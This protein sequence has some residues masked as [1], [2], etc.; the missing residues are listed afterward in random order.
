[1]GPAD[2]DVQRLQ[3]E[4]VSLRRALQDAEMEIQHMTDA[5]QKQIQEM[6]EVL[7]FFQGACCVIAGLSDITICK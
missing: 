1:M 7:L 4:S 3:A 6:S 2:I 5:H